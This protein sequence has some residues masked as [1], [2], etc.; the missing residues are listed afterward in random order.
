[1]DALTRFPMDPLVKPEDD[2]RE[3]K[4]KD[5]EGVVWFYFEKTI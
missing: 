1:M 3:E 5:D 2:A 4:P